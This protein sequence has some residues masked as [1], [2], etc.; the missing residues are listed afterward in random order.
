M[1]NQLKIG[2]HIVQTASIYVVL[3]RIWMAKQ[4]HAMTRC[5]EEQPSQSQNVAE[6][7]LAYSVLASNH[8]Q[9]LHPANELPNLKQPSKQ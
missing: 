3:L 8:L 1:K 9:R 7:S 2:R 6:P 4:K 5:K